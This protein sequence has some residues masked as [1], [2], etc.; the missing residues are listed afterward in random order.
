MRSGISCGALHNPSARVDPDYWRFYILR[1]SHQDFA[2]V[3]RPWHPRKRRI[4]EERGLVDDCDVEV[5][6]A[7]SVMEV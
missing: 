4:C 1:K 5:A 7:V 6:V 3:V 2:S